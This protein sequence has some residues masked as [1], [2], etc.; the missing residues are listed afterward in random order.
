MIDEPSPYWIKI[1]NR[2]NTQAEGHRELAVLWA[3]RERATTAPIAVLGAVCVLKSL[4][5]DDDKPA[6]NDWALRP[7]TASSPISRSAGR[8][9]GSG[10]TFGLEQI[11]V[12][13]LRIDGNC[14]RAGK[15]IDRVHNRVVISRILVNDSDIT[16]AAIRNVDQ[17]L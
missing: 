4:L 17:F 2:N 14:L 7:A 12:V 6:G 5:L 8:G 16:F 9:C 3:R 11:Y 1:K 15:R 13:R 10:A